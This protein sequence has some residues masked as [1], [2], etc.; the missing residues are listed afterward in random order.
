MTS[1]T[2]EPKV[3]FDMNVLVYA[4]DKHDGAK[5]GQ[6]RDLL[7]EAAESDRGVISTQVMQ[8][9]YVVTTRKL[10]LDPLVAKGVL[11][12]FELFEVVTIVPTMISAA[13]DT[14][15]LQ[16]LSFW[17][18]LIVVAAESASCARLVTDDLTHGQ[19]I[20]GVQVVNPFA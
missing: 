2:S 1:T 16:Q 19:V 13:I 4:L 17:D 12:S 9:F 20:R 7:R 6:C 3:F 5:Q 10:G 18:A 11:T 8:E 15:V 14:S